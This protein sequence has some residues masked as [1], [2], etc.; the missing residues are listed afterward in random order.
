MSKSQSNWY[1][2][3]GVKCQ[4]PAH[5]ICQLSDCDI[6]FMERS[7][8]QQQLQKVKQS[9]YRPGQAMRWR[10]PDFKSRHMKAV[11][12][13]LHSGCL[14]PPQEKILVLI[15][16]RGRVIPRAIVQTEGLCQ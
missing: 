9:H 13:A 16:V 4:S 3:I 15:F 1:P 8:R 10:L 11:R 5:Q 2:G 6:Q 14:Y 12:S 7:S